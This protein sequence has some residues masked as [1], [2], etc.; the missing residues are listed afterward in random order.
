MARSSV[1]KR[2]DE[3]TRKAIM[4]DAA[5]E[6]VRGTAKPEPGDREVSLR[7]PSGCG[8]VFCKSAK[9]GR[10][11]LTVQENDVAWLHG[12]HLRRER[13]ALRGRE[14][15]RERCSVRRGQRGC[16]RGW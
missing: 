11:R 1:L 6:D 10:R 14:E 8:Y 7:V 12:S 3:V 16:G 5:F 15:E 13:E 4:S 9:R 2:R